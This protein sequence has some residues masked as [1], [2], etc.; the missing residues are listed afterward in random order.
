MSGSTNFMT[1]QTITARPPQA[2]YISIGR[3]D[4]NKTAFGAWFDTDE[5]GVHDNGEALITVQ[6][7]ASNYYY[8]MNGVDFAAGD[9]TVRFVD[10][11]LIPD[12]GDVAGEMMIH[13]P[14][15]ETYNWYD[16]DLQQSGFGTGDKVIIDKRTNTDGWS[17]ATTAQIAQAVTVN[18][19]VM[20]NLGVPI[21]QDNLT[22]LV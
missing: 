21:T 20:V 4:A 10:P 13:N 18:G 22:F 7:T 5:D 8:K 9:Y 1:E 6:T 15:L 3:L 2:D 19:E 12:Y 14:T 17:S 11:V 16:L